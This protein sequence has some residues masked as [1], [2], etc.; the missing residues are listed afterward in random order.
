MLKVKFVT[1]A[2]IMQWYNRRNQLE[3]KLVTVISLQTLDQLNFVHQTNKW[4]NKTD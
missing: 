4:K 2:K 3:V 1:P